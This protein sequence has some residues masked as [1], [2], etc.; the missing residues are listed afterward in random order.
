MTP[1]RIV[2]KA[3]HWVQ[4]QDDM[5]VPTYAS[6]PDAIQKTLMEIEPNKLSCPKVCLNDF[7]ISMQR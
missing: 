1:V 7:L 3:Q 4:T 6:N 2:Q 5:W